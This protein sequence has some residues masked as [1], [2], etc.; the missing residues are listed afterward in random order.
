VYVFDLLLVDGEAIVDL[1]LRERRARL[2]AALPNMSEGKVELAASMEVSGANATQNPLPPLVE[3]DPLPTGGS[4]VDEKAAAP[5]PSS[6]D[7]P[8]AVEEGNC[9]SGEDS[10]ETTVQEFLLESFS[11]GAE[12]LMLKQLDSGGY[13]PSKRSESWLKVK[14]DYCEGLRDSLDLVPIGAWHGNGRKAGWL[15]PFLLAAWDPVNEEFQSVCRVMSGFTDQFYIDATERLGRQQ[16]IDAPKPYYVTAETCSVWFE[17][18]EVWEIRGADLT[19]SPVHKAA[20][21]HL[22][23]ERGV[24]MRFPRFIRVRDDKSPQDASGPDM[25]VHLFNRQTR[26]AGPRQAPAAGLPGG[27]K[28]GEGCEEEGGRSDGGGDNFWV[29]EALVDKEEH[30]V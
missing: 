12:G 21:G 13:Q 2:P 9:P 23:P 22:H 11:K 3:T 10:A 24:S 7:G 14:R 19:I 20:R 5:L 6:W 4:C 18:M 27:G 15:S 8:A 17:P 26:K 30:D 25:I 16:R 28:E 1:T 29:E